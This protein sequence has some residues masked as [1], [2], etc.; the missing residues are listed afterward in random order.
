MA[1]IATICCILLAFSSMWFGWYLM[2]PGSH[3]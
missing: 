1:T 3:D 2:M